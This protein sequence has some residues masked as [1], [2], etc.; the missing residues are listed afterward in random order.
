MDFW[1]VIPFRKPVSSEINE[2]RNVCSRDHDI[3]RFDIPMNQIKSMHFSETGGNVQSPFE[4]VTKRN[5]FE[6]VLQYIMKGSF[7]SMLDKEA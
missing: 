6:I 7:R 1:S 3:T 2:L 5:T 4:L